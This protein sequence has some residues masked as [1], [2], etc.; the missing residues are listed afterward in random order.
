LTFLDFRLDSISMKIIF[1]PCC[2]GEIVYF[3]QNISEVFPIKYRNYL[4]LLR[5][6]VGAC[7]TE[8]NYNGH[9]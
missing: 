8:V 4:P 7:D 9:G 5:V 2:V 6:R 1:L 3:H